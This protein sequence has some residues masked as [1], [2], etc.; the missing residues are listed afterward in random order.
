MTSEQIW[1]IFK[2]TGSIEAYISYAQSKGNTEKTSNGDYCQN[3]RDNNKNNG[4]IG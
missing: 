3:K 2:N 4:Y 1:K